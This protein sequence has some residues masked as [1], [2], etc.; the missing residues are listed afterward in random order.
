MRF[1]GDESA[2]E[3]SE[4][5]I[6]ANSVAAAQEEAMAGAG[7]PTAIR[8]ARLRAAEAAAELEQ[9]LNALTTERADRTRSEQRRS[10]Q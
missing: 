5:A 7:N 1:N 6:V 9:A 10:S 2:K 3:R 4:R 8:V